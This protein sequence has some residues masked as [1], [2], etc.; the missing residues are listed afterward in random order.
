LSITP[1]QKESPSKPKTPEKATKQPE[2]SVSDAREILD[3][4]PRTS[5]DASEATDKRKSTVDL[6]RRSGRKRMPTEFYKPKPKV[7][8]SFL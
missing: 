8:S 5:N 7:T 2:Q 3:Q 1:E 4:P 6:I